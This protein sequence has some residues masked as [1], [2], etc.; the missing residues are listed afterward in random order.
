MNA[1]PEYISGL[2][3]K[4]PSQIPAHLLRFKFRPDL[5]EYSFNSIIAF[6]IDCSSAKVKVV[7]SAY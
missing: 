5:F 6:V 7:S 3:L 1:I 2:F 4:E